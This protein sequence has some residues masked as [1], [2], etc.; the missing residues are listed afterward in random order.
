MTSGEEKLREHGIRPTAVRELI[1]RTLDAA[2]HPLSSLEIETILDTVDRSTITRALSLFT[3]KELIHV[4]DD[5]S[6]SSKY[7]SC[8]SGSH[9]DHDD[10]HPHFHCIS[11][12]KTVCIH[13]ATI[14]LIPLP[15]G[16]IAKKSNL[17]IS[18]LCS[19]CAANINAM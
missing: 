19:S 11:C 5:G 7:E 1:L 2:D 4:I 9:H 12:G 6:G 16:F 15:K 17:T 13:S 8:L 3:E 18:G 14:P 10:R